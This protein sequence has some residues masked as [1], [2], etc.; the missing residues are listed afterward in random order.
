[1]KKLFWVVALLFICANVSFAGNDSTSSSI[2]AENTFTSAIS[3]ARKVG[4]YFPEGYL[5]VSI[6][7][8]WSGTVTLQRSFDS[9]STWVDVETFTANDEGY[10]Y[11]KERGILY[12]IGIKTGEYT[13][14]TA[15][16]RLSN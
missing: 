2:A 1:M 7:G 15:V 8:T 3:P 10:L 9:G 14:G 6:S 5:N 13:S 12:R 11:D 4:A 16:V